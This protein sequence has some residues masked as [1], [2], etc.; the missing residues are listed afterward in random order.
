MWNALDSDLTGAEQY[1]FDQT[2]REIFKGKCLLSRPAYSVSDVEGLLVEEVQLLR[3]QIRKTATPLVARSG[4]KKP[5][6]NAN[7]M[8]V[9]S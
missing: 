2:A 5:I 8:M 7:D 6:V 4:S 9:Q 1:D 3:D